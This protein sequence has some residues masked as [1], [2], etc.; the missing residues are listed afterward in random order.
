MAGS[1]QRHGITPLGGGS[2]MF[3]GPVAGPVNPGPGRVWYVSTSNASGGNGKSWAQAFTT[4][5]AAFAVLDSGDTIL[6]TGKV[7]EQVST[8]A[9]VFDVSI[10]GAGTTRHGDAH[11]GNNG[12]QASS[13]WVTPGSP[14][15]ATPLLTV[16]QQGWKL[17]NI[18]FDGPSDAAAVQLFRDAG[19]GDAEDDASHAHI[20]GCKFVAGQNHIEL[21]GGLSQVI[22][23]KNIFFGATA[24]SILE[25]TGAGV[26]TNNYH[27]FLDNIWHDNES[28]ID[29]ALNFA[30]IRGNTFGKFTTD[31]LNVIGGTYNSIFGNSFSGTYSIAGGYRTGTNDEWGGNYNSLSGGVTAA[32]PA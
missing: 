32:D 27:R 26:G 31:A 7:A 4:M 19:A 21:K 15:A 11:T 17:V 22:I 1:A 14:T 25:T 18:L 30:T 6:M 23:E 5:T 29:V 2:Y 3:N 24:D 8:P 9:G 28:H 16:R 10:I 12:A 13:S 20:F